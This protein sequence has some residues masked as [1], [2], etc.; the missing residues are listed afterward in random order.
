MLDSPY[1]RVISGPPRPSRILT[2]TSLAP[3][4]GRERIEVAGADAVLIRLGAG[5]RITLTNTEGGQRCEVVAADTKGRI[6]A[7]ILGVP[8]NSDAAGLKALL[9]T[10][11]AGLRLGLKRRGIDL[12]R[13]GGVALFGEATPAGASETF[14]AIQDGVLIVAAPGA[15]MHP[16]EQT[17]ATPIVVTLQRAVLRKQGIAGALDMQG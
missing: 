10:G 16:G 4:S 9:A 17:T 13:A 2:P 15:A 8:A 5:D 3:H 14:T 11:L 7:G 12:D 6:D 1:P